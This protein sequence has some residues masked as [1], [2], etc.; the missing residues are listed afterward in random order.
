M[1]RV[2]MLTGDRVERGGALL[3]EVEVERRD[4]LA[5]LVRGEL[6]DA[7]AGRRLRVI[8]AALRVL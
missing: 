8:V 1:V 7:A 4:V 6:Q 2:R 3:A 5:R